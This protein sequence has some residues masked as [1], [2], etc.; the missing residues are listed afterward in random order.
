MP[1]RAGLGSTS[2]T[3]LYVGRAVGG[4]GVGLISAVVPT[5]ISESAPRAVRGR[6]TS[7][8]QWLNV[9]GIMLS[10]WINYGLS[11]H[12]ATYDPSMWRTSFALQIIPGL[13]CGV[14][15]LFQHESPRWLV[16]ND[17]IDEARVALAWTH[18]ADI[19]DPVVNATLEEIKLDYRLRPKLSPMQQLRVI[20][21]SGV[22][23]YRSSIGC[24]AMFFQQFTGTNSIN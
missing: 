23:F 15:L 4:F 22:M 24:I 9:T 18:R 17:R 14:G 13:L 16:E 7:T 11:I 21:S 20:C 3:P 5:F 12:K 19:N 10:Y 8:Y 2:L 6:C 1:F